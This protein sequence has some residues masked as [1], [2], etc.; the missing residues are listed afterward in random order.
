FYTYGHNDIWRKN[1][2]WRQALDSPGACQMGILKT[3]LT[4]REWWKQVPDQSVFTSAT[5]GEEPLKIA[6]RS[7]E[8]DSIVVYLSSPTTVSIDMRKMKAGPLVHATW[9]NPETG[10]QMVIGRFRST[11]QHSFA[12]PESWQ[13]AV[14]LLE[15]AKPHEGRN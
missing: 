2:T 5:R 8:G 13:D 14:L 6:T 9:V 12:T 1:V 15:A 3:I 10:G 11:G 7:T 4:S